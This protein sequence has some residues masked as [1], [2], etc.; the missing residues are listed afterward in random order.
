MHNTAYSMLSERSKGY[1]IER[2][3]GYSDSKWL[4]LPKPHRT[5]WL[6]L[7]SDSCQWMDMFQAPVSTVTWRSLLPRLQER[8]W[9]AK[10][11]HWVA[12]SLLRVRFVSDS[13]PMYVATY[14]YI[15]SS[16]TNCS[17][18]IDWNTVELDAW[19]C[20]SRRPSE[21]ISFVVTFAFDL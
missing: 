15:Y 7:Q 17:F 16:S 20:G 21:I 4:Q 12:I 5:D 18:A 19:R 14:E 6:D 9:R 8:F 3:E 10:A 11:T 2:F 13:Q 1:S